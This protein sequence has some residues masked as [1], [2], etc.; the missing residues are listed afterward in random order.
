MNK[1]ITIIT[2]NQSNLTNFSKVRN[3]ELS[4]VKTPWVM[5]LDSDEKLTS[6]LTQAIDQAIKNKDYNYQLKRQDWFLGSLLKFGETSRFRS[7]RLVQKGTGQWQGKVHETFNSTLPTKTLKYPLIHQRNINVTSF[8]DRLNTY[9]SF[10]ATEEKQFSLL[11]LLLYPP[12]KFIQNYFFRLG[13]LDGLPGLIMAF[14]MSLHSL[15]VR[16][17]VYEKT[18]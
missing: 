9:S 11:K 16:I 13:F 2:L 15:W 1:S 10:K 17:K 7:I 5:F 14:S 18:I 6:A 12:S 8:I 4:K 3:L